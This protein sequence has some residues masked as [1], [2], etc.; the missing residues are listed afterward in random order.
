M[1]RYYRDLGLHPIAVVY[2]SDSLHDGPANG[3]PDETDDIAFLPA[4]LDW[5]DI[6]TFP[7]TFNTSRTRFE[8]LQAV[9]FK[10]WLFQR[11]MADFLAHP[12]SRIKD[13]Q[14][15]REY[16]AE[17]LYRYTG[18]PSSL[19]G[20]T[21]DLGAGKVGWEPGE[22][23]LSPAVRSYIAGLKHNLVEQANPK[24]AEFTRDWYEGAAELCREMG[25]KLIVF[26]VPRGPLQ[27]LTPP[28]GEAHGALADLAAAGKL[29]L[30]D[31]D[32]FDDLEHPQFFFDALH[33]NR[34]GREAFS[35]RLARETLR[36][37]AH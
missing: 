27:F 12:A 15:W 30:M 25:A 33:M 13:V 10:G 31:P 26:R 17:W 18:N 32:T 8:A 37:L 1:L 14:L 4:F 21:L 9:L 2:A 36:I 19:A 22:D 24:Y 20:L 29:T 11:D 16:G 5:K 23:K 3:D 7:L 28:L 35:P 34:V 6:V